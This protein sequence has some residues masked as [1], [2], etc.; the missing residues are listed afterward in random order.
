LNDFDRAATAPMKVSADE[1]FQAYRD[2]LWPLWRQ[3]GLPAEPLAR[4]IYSLAGV[5]PYAEDV[6]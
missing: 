4:H 5:N 1:T 3:T 6:S 2:R